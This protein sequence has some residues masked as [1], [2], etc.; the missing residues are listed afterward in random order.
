MWTKGGGFATVMLAP[1]SPDWPNL[2]A[3]RQVQADARDALGVIAEGGAVQRRGIEERANRETECAKFA[4][5]PVIVPPVSGGEIELGADLHPKRRGRRVDAP[6]VL[7]PGDVPTAVWSAI[8][9]L[10]VSDTKVGGRLS[11]CG[12]P[13]CGRFNLAFEGKAQRHCSPLHRRRYDATRASA[14][15]RA[16]RARDRQRAAAAAGAPPLPARGASRPK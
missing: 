7:L 2:E 1:F 6:L 11:R 4:Q 8:L 15:M 5:R 9:H 12:A 3:C 14:R 13:G 16:K 10:L